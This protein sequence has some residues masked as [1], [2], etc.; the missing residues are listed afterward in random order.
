MA[1]RHPAAKLAQSFWLLARNVD[2]F[3]RHHLDGQWMH[4]TLWFGAGTVDMEAVCRELAQEPF[5][6]LTPARIAGAEDEDVGL[7]FDEA[8][9]RQWQA[10][11]R[12]IIRRPQGVR[13][14]GSRKLLSF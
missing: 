4:L 8:I 2:P 1:Y 3:F 7:H 9:S 5:R 14:N 12:L 11:T 13:S 10:A 6:H